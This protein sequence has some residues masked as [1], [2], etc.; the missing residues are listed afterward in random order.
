MSGCSIWI[1][2]IL[3][4]I[5]HRRTVDRHHIYTHSTHRVNSI[6]VSSCCT[7][8]ILCCLRVLGYPSQTFPRDI[9]IKCGARIRI[10][11]ETQLFLNYHYARPFWGVTAPVQNIHSLTLAV[12]IV[13]FR[14]SF[15]Y[16]TYV[17]ICHTRSGCTSS[18]QRKYIFYVDLTTLLWYLSAGLS[19]HGQ[20]ALQR[21]SNVTRRVTCQDKWSAFRNCEPSVLSKMCFVTTTWHLTSGKV[22]ALKAGLECGQAKLI[23]AVSKT[24]LRRTYQR[25]QFLFKAANL[26]Q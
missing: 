19:A 11:V 10:K 5:Q 24:T 3:Y 13:W 12:C 6:F 21:A 16:R 18:V 7:M 26:L 23:S 14:S 17:L 4:S 22:G 25:L 15:V 9:S 2:T 20:R 8:R 1:E